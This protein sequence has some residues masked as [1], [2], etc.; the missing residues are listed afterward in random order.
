MHMQQAETALGTEWP[1][2]EITAAWA[3][4]GR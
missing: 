2:H 1:D 3:R 4:V